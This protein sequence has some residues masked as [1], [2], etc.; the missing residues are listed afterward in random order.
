ML[1][2]KKGF[3]TSILICIV[4]TNYSCSDKLTEKYNASVPVYMSY[5]ELR[6]AV[7]TDKHEPLAAPGKIYFKDKYIF[8]NEQM[9]GVHVI[10]NTDPENPKFKTFISIPGNVDIAIKENILY[11]DS[12]I[13]LVA[14]DI[15]DLNKIKETHRIKD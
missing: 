14:L 2:T 3:L 10:D 4:F 11:A 1:K 7:S 12:Y 15:S 13:D 9:K 5:A 8:I 6:D